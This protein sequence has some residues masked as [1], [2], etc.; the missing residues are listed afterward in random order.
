MTE[1]A[2]R[3]DT[4]QDS[5]EKTSLMFV[6]HASLLIKKGHRYLLTDPWYLRAGFGSW[7][8]TFQQYVH[9]TYLAALGDKLTIL[10]SHGHDDHCDDDLLRIFDRNTEIVTASFNAPSVLNRLKKLGFNNLTTA[11][12]DQGAVLKNGFAV[13]SYVDP[14]RSLDDA[15]YTIDTG[16]G[17]VVHC[18]DNWFEFEPKA[19]ASI[20]ADRA[21]YANHNVAFFSQTNS[22]S[23]HPLSYTCF[24]DQQKIRI[25]R[26][27]VKGMVV[28]GMK[29]ADALGLDSF[30][31]YAGFASIF[32]KEFPSYLDLALIPTA[33]FI[34]DDLLDDPDSRA[35]LARVNVRD[36]YPGDV[37][38]LSSGGIAAAFISNAD[39]SDKQL[40]DATV[41]YY[42]A[43]GVIDQCDTFKP[44]REDA[45]V[46]Q[47]R[48]LYFLDNLNKFVARKIQGDAKFFE[49]II[50]KSLEVVVPDAGV[51]AT[52]VFGGDVHLGAH[53]GGLPN[54]RITASS[55]LMSQVLSGEILFENL[56]SGYEGQWE[57]FPSDVY[58][59]DIVMFVVMYSYVYQ[60]RLAKTAPPLRAAE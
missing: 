38:D 4:K 2:E 40:K 35:L 9:P 56:Y 41:R 18:N 36:F 53:K 6:N 22:A 54:K 48:L 52:V 59:R 13:K 57:R 28:Q 26:S 5:V 44:V 29:N 11:D 49:T 43:Y 42:E 10:I 37:L 60:N 30:Y 39:Y 1:H 25:L 50:G 19:L 7:L 47:G 15:T 20:A 8:P 27:K 17:L 45:V 14:T 21:K 46:D 58:N 3:Q 51:T 24:D 12:S 32:V 23:G 55:L 33:K 16:T 31:S 34:R